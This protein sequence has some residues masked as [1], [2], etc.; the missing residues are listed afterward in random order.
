M[1]LLTGGIFL[2]P[3]KCD[4]DREVT[5]NTSLEQQTEIATIEAVNIQKS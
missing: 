5:S 4:R 1:L 3:T 2:F